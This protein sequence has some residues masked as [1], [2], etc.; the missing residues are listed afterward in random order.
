MRLIGLTGKA[1]VGKDFLAR[2]ILRPAGYLKVAFAT[3]LKMDVMAHHGFTFDEVFFEK[4]PHVRKAL[5][6]YGVA[7][8]AAAPDYWLARLD[9]TLQQL[10]RDAGVEKFVITDVRFPNEVDFVRERG[11]KVVRMLH[12][13]RPYPLAGT[14]AAAHASEIALDHL[15][16]QQFDATILNH[17]DRRGMSIVQRLYKAGVIDHREL[18]AAGAHLEARGAPDPAQLE[19]V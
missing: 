2:E 11:G 14:P 13:N 17:K 16:A 15:S 9:R 3:A 8:R 4:P 7:K 18:V 5:Q 1:G 10:H 19:L 6:E 12:G